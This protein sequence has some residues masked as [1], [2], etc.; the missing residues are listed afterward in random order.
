MAVSQHQ[1]YLDRKHSKVSNLCTFKPVTEVNIVN[2]LVKVSSFLQRLADS[3]CSKYKYMVSGTRYK[4]KENIQYYKAWGGK[5]RTVKLT[6]NL[7]PELKQ[8]AKNMCKSWTD[9]W[10]NKIAESL[11]SSGKK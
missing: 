8:E 7:T 1:F 4:T 9:R 3:Q 11:I 2:L 6:V 5:T 10:L